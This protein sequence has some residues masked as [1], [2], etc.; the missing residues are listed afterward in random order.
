MEKNRVLVIDDSP[1][2]QRIIKDILTNA[3]YEVCAC[4]DSGSEGIAKYQ[5]YQPDVVTMDLTLPDMDGLECSCKILYINPMAKIIV[6]SAMK[7][8]VL[9]NKGTAIGVK[10]YLQKPVK[11]AELLPVLRK[12]IAEEQPGE[13]NKDHELIQHFVTAFEKNLADMA[14]LKSETELLPGTSTT[15][16]SNGMAIIVGITGSRQGRVILDVS[17]DIAQYL[18]EKILGD[19]ASEEDLL[20]S[21]SELANIIAGHGVSQINNLYKDKKLELRLTPPSILLGKS[22]SIINLK[23]AASTIKA[24]TGVGTVYMNVGFMGRK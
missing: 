9:V 20:N 24:N 19:Q 22:L 1:F 3:G 12:I 18:S 10:D 6:L 5:E 15:F 4:A 17:D 13:E 16:V 21:L 8:E 23:L 11:A 14:G 2:S 7:D